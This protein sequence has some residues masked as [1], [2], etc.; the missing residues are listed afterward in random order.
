MFL[1]LNSITPFPAPRRGIRVR[2]PRQ[3]HLER[4]MLCLQGH[5][6]ILRI[7]RDVRFL[8]AKPFRKP[9]PVPV[10][11]LRTCSRFV[12]PVNGCTGRMTNNHLL[13]LLSC[14]FVPFPPKRCDTISLWP[15]LLSVTSRQVGAKST[16]SNFVPSWHEVTAPNFLPTWQEV[17]LC[18]PEN[19]GQLVRN[20]CCWSPPQK[21]GTS[22]PTFPAAFFKNSANLAQLF[23]DRFL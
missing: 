2:V 19:S 16:I 8:W 22:C 6:R 20:F 1:V 9:T 18:S 14:L 21:C 13:N 3:A 17:N 12:Y 10:R 4:Q 11:S 7:P 23:Y 15:H 5:P